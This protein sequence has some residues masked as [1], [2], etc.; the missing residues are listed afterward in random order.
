M[1]RK[2][3]YETL[4]L[5][6]LQVVGVWATPYNKYGVVRGVQMR[7]VKKTSKHR[8]KTGAPCPGSL[9]AIPDGA[10]VPTGAVA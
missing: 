10:A 7:P 8:D 4:C 5:T 9:L 6:C 1:P 2:P 3:N